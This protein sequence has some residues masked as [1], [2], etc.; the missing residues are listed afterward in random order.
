MR[1]IELDVYADT[2]GGLYAHPAGPA[3]AA[4]AGLP[5]D[6]PFDPDGIMMKPGFKVMHVQDVD[7]RSNCQ[8]FTARAC[9]KCVNGRMRIQ[10][11]SPSSSW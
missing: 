7:Y 8:P 2:K 9:S 5:A 11:T 10:S 4:A 3:M 6:P 1:Q